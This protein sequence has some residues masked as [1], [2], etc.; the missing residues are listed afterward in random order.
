M[1][2][3]DQSFETFNQWVDCA[4]RWLTE[5]PRYLE[6]REPVNQTRAAPGMLPFRAI[7]FD[8]RGRLCR[9][10]ADF[11]RARD[12]GAFPVRW[13][14]PDQVGATIRGMEQ[15][16]AKMD[17]EIEARLAQCEVASPSDKPDACDG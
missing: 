16:I 1:S 15:R 5:H 7:C 14:W 10:G 11:M 2:Q 3:I 6:T 9:S 4:S 8:A 13:V 17:A 12:E